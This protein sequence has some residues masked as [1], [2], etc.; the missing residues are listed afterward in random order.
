MAGFGGGFQMGVDGPKVSDPV[1]PTQAV[2]AV[3]E[4]EDVAP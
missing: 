3:F 2:E 4:Q 1:I